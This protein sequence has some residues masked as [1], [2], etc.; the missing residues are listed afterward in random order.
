MRH[1][2]VNADTHP[3]TAARPTPSLEAPSPERVVSAISDALDG[4]R[5]LGLR[6]WPVRVGFEDGTLELEGDVPSLAVKRRAVQLAARHPGI[7][8]VVDRLRVAP[9]AAMSDAVIRDHVMDALIEDAAFRQCTVRRQ[10][11]DAQG[12]DGRE[13]VQ[14]PPDVRGD[15]CVRVERGV[16][17]LRGVV[18]TRAHERLAGVLSWWVPGTRDV[19]S[20]LAVAADDRDTDDDITAALRTALEKDPIV[21]ASQVQVETVDRVVTLRGLVWSEDE[22]TMAENDAWYVFHVVDVVNAL[23]VAEPT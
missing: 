13:V 10:S 1:T 3:V 17:T 19:V 7:T 21:D 23:R 14:A 4:D 6:D 16:V 22:R 2:L 9:P 5:R 20:E 18:P 12:K 8:R 15:M 11:K